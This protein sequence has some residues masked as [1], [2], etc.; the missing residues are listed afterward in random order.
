MMSFGNQSNGSARLLILLLT[1]ALVVS[2]GANIWLI[3]E[4]GRAFGK[5]QFDRNF[6][7]GFV[8]PA[9]PEP[10]SPHAA[11]LAVY[12][13]SRAAGWG[14][15]L[16]ADSGLSVENLAHGG[17][18]SSQL[19]LQLSTG[20]AYRSRAALVQIG[21]NDL[22]P[23]G[24]LP[25]SKLAIVGRLHRNL[26]L[27]VERLLERSDVV[28]VTTIFPPARVP[29]ARRL[30]WDDGTLGFI[31]SANEL[32]RRLARRDRVVLMDASRILKSSSGE[33]LLKYE[34]R[35]FYLH[36]NQRAYE[37]LSA[38]LLPVLEGALGADGLAMPE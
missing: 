12:G 3:C 1:G 15:Y 26:T 18:T 21:I 35:T 30:F 9:D 10:D 2:V 14:Q 36:V 23:L 20:R 27:I 34:D 31:T 29:F 16:Q 19:L 22:H 33:I 4:L 7:L 11:T 17:I 6:P 24:V 28:I 37:A 25:S 38:G 5:I 13:D 8:P 32:I